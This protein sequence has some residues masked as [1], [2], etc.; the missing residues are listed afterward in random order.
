MA[1]EKIYR[2]EMNEEG[3]FLFEIPI[4]ALA[5]KRVGASWK[6]HMELLKLVYNAFPDAMECIT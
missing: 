1:I 3:F 2:Y 6:E 5:K 4:F